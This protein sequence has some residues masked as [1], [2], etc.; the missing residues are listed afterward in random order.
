MLILSCNLW[1][2]DMH[3]SH[4]A[5]RVCNRSCHISS[6]THKLLCKITVVLGRYV[7][8]NDWIW[9]TLIYHHQ[10]GWFFLQLQRHTFFNSPRPR[11]LQSANACVFWGERVVS[12]FSVG[13]YVFGWNMM[14]IWANQLTKIW[15][16]VHYVD[17]FAEVYLC[18]QFH[19]LWRWW[20]W[21]N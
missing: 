15:V 4:Y 1:R 10:V 6:I 21:A 8:L 11:N 20:W 2:N 12:P 5:C 18:L 17:I 3:Y 16:H 19:R 13:T 14:V 9:M 7:S